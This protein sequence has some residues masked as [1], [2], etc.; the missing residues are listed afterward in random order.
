MAWIGF[1]LCAFFHAQRSG[2]LFQ[3]LDRFIQH[4]LEAFVHWTILISGFGVV[5]GIVFQ[6]KRP[7]RIVGLGIAF[8]T[9]VFLWA[10]IW[11]PL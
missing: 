3:P 10:A 4:H 1:V 8:S 9:L 6:L 2:F 11:S 5:A 7:S